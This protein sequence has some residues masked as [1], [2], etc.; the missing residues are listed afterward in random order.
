M[1]EKWIEIFKAGRWTDSSGKTRKWS[2]EDLDRTVSRYAVRGNDAPAVIGCPK[3]GLSAYGCVVGLKRD[4][5][6]LF[7]RI[8]P[9]AKEVAEWV[10][11]RLYRRVS[12]SLGPDFS[13]RHVGFLGGARP[14]VKGLKA[15]EFAEEEFVEIE[16][17]ISEIRTKESA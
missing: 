5:D 13:L 15:P 10:R 14:A 3:S 7:A 12:I 11:K 9:T 16:V 17:D 1:E 4:G 2:R 8:R 6:L